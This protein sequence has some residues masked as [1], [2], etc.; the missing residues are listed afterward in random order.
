MHP[1]ESHVR[2]HMLHTPPPL[3]SLH[4][5]SERGPGRSRPPPPAVKGCKGLHR[6]EHHSAGA[7]C[8]KCLVLVIYPALGLNHSMLKSCIYLRC[9]WQ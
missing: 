5:Q 2:E 3:P 4:I 7:V 1:W 9:A 6:M 8:A